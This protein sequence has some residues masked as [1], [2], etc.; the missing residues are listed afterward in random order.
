MSEEMLFS[1]F[2]EKNEMLT[3]TL[4]SMLTEDFSSIKSPENRWKRTLES[5]F[6][7]LVKVVS[8]FFVSRV[9]SK[10]VVKIQSYIQDFFERTDHILA[11]RNDSRLQNVFLMG[12]CH[13]ID[14]MINSFE[15]AEAFHQNDS[16]KSVISSYEYMK[17]VILCLEKN[18]RM[19]HKELAGQVNMSESELSDFM[20]KVQE[21]NLFHSS[22]INK[23]KY[24]SL[25]YPNGEEALKI[26]KEDSRP[27]ADSYTDFLLELL[28]LLQDIY[29]RNDVNTVDA[30]KKCGDMVCQY[31]TKPALCK[32]KMNDLAAILN[33]VRFNSATLIIYERAIVQ[34]CVTIFTRNIQSEEV[35]KESV[36][37]NLNKNVTYRWFVE[38]SDEFDSIDKIKEY[39]LGQFM[40]GEEK[41][42]KN[43]WQNALFCMIQ[44]EEMS[45]LLGN[46]VSDA[47]IFDWKIGFSC[48][49]QI[50]SDQTPY[51]Q[52]Q[53]EEINMF[54]QYVQKQNMSAFH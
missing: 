2:A 14:K 31:T 30:L 6:S 49:D 28:G 47:V 34:Q 13:A 41:P 38:T 39:F 26:V 44:K 27:S 36:I 50:I 22:Y 4:N 18:I 46:D 32:K 51:I 48:E 16:L 17:P 8:R 29:L 54:Y 5:L 42:E 11:V 20:D 37:E 45:E 10:E 35:F 53:D 33:S 19:S 15:K 24:Y 40:Q 12:Y 52:M 25:A 43:I 21:Y 1:N 3:S 7:S 23:D 9:K